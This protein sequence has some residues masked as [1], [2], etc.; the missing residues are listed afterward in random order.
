M[1]HAKQLSERLGEVLL[2]GRWV[3]NTN[4][5]EQLEAIDWQLAAK[6]PAAGNS[7]ALLA[8]HIHYYIAG[9]KQVFEGGS[10]DIRDKYSFDFPEMTSSLQW[11]TFLETFRKD[12]AQ[13][14]KHIAELPDDQLDEPFVDPK[15]G[16]DRRNI[17]GMIE[18]CYYHLGQVVLLRKQ[19]G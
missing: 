1:E 9:V 2:N 3:A 8:R 16:T 18:H 7:I 6:G 13:L 17:N 12:A 10:M 11:Q 19:L 15:Y 4:F 5:R 14:V